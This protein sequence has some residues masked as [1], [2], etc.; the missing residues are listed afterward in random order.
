MHARTHMCK[1]THIHELRL[2]EILG[3]GSIIPPCGFWRLNLGLQPSWPWH[4]FLIL[5]YVL[6]P[7]HLLSTYVGA[8]L[9]PNIGELIL[10]CHRSIPACASKEQGHCHGH[11]QKCSLGM[12]SL[13]NR[14][15]LVLK[16]LHCPDKVIF[17]LTFTVGWFFSLLGCVFYEIQMSRQTS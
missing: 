12:P 13:C 2:E 4:Q 15:V 5:C 1:G 7:P 14:Q 9:P 8:F 16:C 17:I 11:T 3:F 10:T 6:S